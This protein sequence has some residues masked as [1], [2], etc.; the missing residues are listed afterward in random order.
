MVRTADSPTLTPKSL[1]VLVAHSHLPIRHLLK[2]LE[3][4]AARPPRDRRPAWATRLIEKLS[5][6]FEPIEG[7][8]RVGFDCRLNEDCWEL[9]MYLGRTEVVGGPQ[10]GEDQPVDFSLDLRGITGVLGPCE[11]L[12]WTVIHDSSMASERMP[13]SLLRV[14]TAWEGNRVRVLFASHPPQEVGPAIRRF[15][16][17]TCEL[18]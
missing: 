9:S 5:E 18:L 13:R 7:V 1:A 12:E 11:I 6:F 10:D 3:T 4:H 2:H 15:A 17:G 14:E 8:A 16:D